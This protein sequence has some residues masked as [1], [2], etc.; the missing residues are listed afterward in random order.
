M[1]EGT[2]INA[3][4]PSALG[5]RALVS[6]YLPSLIIRTLGQ[7]LPDRTNAET[8]APPHLSAYM[9]NGNSG[10]RFVDI[11]FANGG[12]G[13]R[14]TMDG[15]SSLGFP[16]NISGVPVEVTENE[17]PLMFLHK[18]LGDRLRWAGQTPR[19]AWPRACRQ[20]NLGRQDHIRD[21]HGPN[22]APNRWGCRW[23]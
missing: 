10:R 12:L 6:M 20:V 17:K 18:E 15:V 11:L 23:T 1:P 14:P 4:F 7:A 21:A 22:K 3:T 13:A 2:V 8:G 16:S 19:R 5:G 9:G